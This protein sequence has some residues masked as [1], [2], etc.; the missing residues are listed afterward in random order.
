LIDSDRGDYE[1]TDQ[2]RRPLSV[3]TR[4]PKPECEDTDDERSEQR[5]HDR[6]A[7]PEK[8][9]AADHHG[10]DAFDIR[11]LTGRRRDRADPADQ[12]PARKAQM[13]PASM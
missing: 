4:K 5:A 8:G 11:Q 9:D 1:Q 2:E 3:R 10:C 7:A 13:K 6:T 12:G